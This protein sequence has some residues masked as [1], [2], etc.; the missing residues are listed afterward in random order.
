ML[1]G[2]RTLHTVF[3]LKIRHLLLFGT[4]LPN[5]AKDLYIRQGDSQNLVCVFSAPTCTI[6]THALIDGDQS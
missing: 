3:L 5:W 4:P 6:L 2:N 1:I